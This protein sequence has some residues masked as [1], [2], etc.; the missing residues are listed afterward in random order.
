MTWLIMV[1]VI[2]TAY[3]NKCIDFDTIT[4]KEYSLF[5][6]QIVRSSLI[7]IYRSAIFRTFISVSKK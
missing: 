2:T 4:M 1:I 3:V 5:F 7:I 6:L